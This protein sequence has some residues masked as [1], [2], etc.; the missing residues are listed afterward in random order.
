MNDASPTLFPEEHTFLVA[1]YWADA[2]ISSGV[3][4]IPYE[5]FSSS[6]NPPLSQLNWFIGRQE[7]VDFEGRWALIAEW[8]RVSAFGDSSGESVSYFLKLFFRI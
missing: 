5:V 8:K 3:G 7:E 6:D 2:D 4:E 1:P